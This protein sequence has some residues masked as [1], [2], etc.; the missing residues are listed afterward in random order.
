LAADGKESF[1]A[2]DKARPGD[3]L[4]YAAVCKNVSPDSIHNLKP[5][6]P[7]PAGTELLPNSIKPAATEASLDGKKFEAYPIKRP[8][9]TADGK[10]ELREVPAAQ[11]RALRWNVGDLKGGA[12]TTLVARVRVT[13]AK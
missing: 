8:V 7:I 4:E 11:I 5:N 12:S 2:A 9:K 6:L 13:V 10:E 1:E 3:T